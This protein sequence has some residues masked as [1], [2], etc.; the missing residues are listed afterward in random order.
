[1]TPD[2]CPCCGKYLKTIYDFPRIEILATEQVGTA[3]DVPDA[4]DGGIVATFGEK[5]GQIEPD[6]EHD[7]VVLER[8]P[9]EVIDHFVKDQS[10]HLYLASDGFA[11][12]MFVTNVNGPRMYHRLENLARTVKE[13]ISGPVQQFCDSLSALVGK[14]VPIDQVMPPFEQVKDNFKRIPPQARQIPG[15][16]Y[17]LFF[18]EGDPTELGRVAEVKVWDTLALRHYFTEKT[19]CFLHLGNLTYRGVLKS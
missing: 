6:I 13:A 3:D 8:A 17:A 18:E 11:Y 5:V 10:F 9:Q 14:I 16:G 4:I 15:C 1:M 12:R 7:G 2:Q 19:P